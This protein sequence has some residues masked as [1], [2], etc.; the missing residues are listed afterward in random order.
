MQRPF[1]WL[2]GIALPAW[3]IM[4]R[5]VTTDEGL[6]KPWNLLAEKLDDVTSDAHLFGAIYIVT[7]RRPAL[8][9][10]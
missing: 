2:A 7:G 10:G 3:L 6:A 9:S 5:Y 8:S 1:L 4:R